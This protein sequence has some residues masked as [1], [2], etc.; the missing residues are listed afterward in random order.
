MIRKPKRI[1]SILL[2]GF[3][4][5]SAF[6][7]TGRISVEGELPK[8]DPPAYKVNERKGWSARVE[9]PPAYEEIELLKMDP[10]AN[11]KKVTKGRFWR[12]R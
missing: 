12:L 6:D 5:I 10:F 8:E 1:I 11:G 7:P 3:S 4:D 9:K 2:L